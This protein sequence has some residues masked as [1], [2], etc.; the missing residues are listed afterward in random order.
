MNRNI[1]DTFLWTSNWGDV[2]GCL[3]CDGA[4]YSAS[5]YGALAAALGVT[6]SDAGEFPV[7]DLTG[8]APTDLMPYVVARGHTRATLRFQLPTIASWMTTTWVKSSTP[9]TPIHHRDGPC[10]TARSCP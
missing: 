7:P 8:S 9:A 1:G 2:Q 4:N 5:E 10:A 6:P 3:R